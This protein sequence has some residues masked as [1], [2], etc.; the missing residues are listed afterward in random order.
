MNPRINIVKSRYLYP[1]IPKKRPNKIKAIIV[2]IFR[3]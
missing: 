3:A 2:Y 1:K